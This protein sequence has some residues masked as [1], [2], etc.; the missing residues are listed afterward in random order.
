[1]SPLGARFAILSGA[2]SSGAPSRPW[3]SGSS[4]PAAAVQDRRAP[5][6]TCPLLHPPT[7]REPLDADA[8]SADSRAHRA[9]RGA[10]DVTEPPAQ[11]GELG[12]R[13]AAGGSP[14]R[15]VTGG[16]PSADVGGAGAARTRR[17]TYANGR[18]IG[19]EDVHVATRLSEPRKQIDPY[20]KSRRRRRVTSPL[21]Q[22]PADVVGLSRRD[23]RVGGSVPDLGRPRQHRLPGPRCANARHDRR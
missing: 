20:W 6:P 17:V 23:V 21:T 18:G 3:W 7:G 5:H 2:T 22:E 11:G 14:R 1:M 4:P 8:L 9:T 19:G 13:P 12:R 15:V 16:R 10:S